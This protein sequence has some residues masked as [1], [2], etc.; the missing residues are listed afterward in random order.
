MMQGECSSTS[1]EAE[2]RGSPTG[3]NWLALAS[4]PL[5]V[6]KIVSLGCFALPLDPS[7]QIQIWSQWSL[8]AIKS[9]MR[10]IIF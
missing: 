7:S 3:V 9:T 10:H 2:T 1:I 8:S 6:V 4:S 5:A